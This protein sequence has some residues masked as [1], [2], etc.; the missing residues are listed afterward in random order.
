[1]G[2]GKM[3]NLFYEI[4]EQYGTPFYLFD[5]DRLKE[6]IEKVNCHFRGYHLC[7]CIKANPFVIPFVVP[8]VSL[9]EVCSPG[10]FA[11]CRHYSVDPDK[12]FYTGIYKNSDDIK[13][14]LEYGV[15]LF[16]CESIGQFENLDKAAEC[17]DEKVNV[18]LRYGKCN[19]F[20]LEEKELLE[21]INNRSQY[22]L[23][24]KG[25]H[26]FE[27]SQKRNTDKIN[28]ELTDIE[29]LCTK[30]RKEY[31]FEI[32]NIEYGLGLDVDYFSSDP[33]ETMD[34]LLLEVSDVLKQWKR[35]PS[36]TIEMGRFFVASCGYYVTKVVD[37][38]QKG[39]VRYAVL[40][41][42]H[43]QMYYD[44]Q[45]LG[46]KIPIVHNLGWTEEKDEVWTLCGC[47][48]THNDIIV[49]NIVI[50][51]LKI[52]DI[53]SFE[54]IGAYSITEGMTSFLIRDIP[55]VIIIGKGL[56]RTPESRIGTVPQTMPMVCGNK[57]I[58]MICARKRMDTWCLNC[59]DANVV[60]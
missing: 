28:E 52:N 57:D 3:D 2:I 10:E 55:P 8:Y 32:Q 60:C 44:G 53:L 50:K 25:I 56:E 38:K 40:D 22:R 37:I 31:D 47:L 33:E 24:I 41:G 35:M 1:M 19:Q 21:I 48:C 14:A 13:A 17:I 49:R 16:S 58:G 29:Q 9:L 59:M 39:N 7:Y 20:G 6:Q 30:I 4:A 43:H 15:R 23:C 5:M 54:Y 42:G 51:D 27:K 46:M 12:I 45:M 26:Y 18:Y 36:V 34:K 11:L